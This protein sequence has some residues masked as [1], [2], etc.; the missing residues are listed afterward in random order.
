[1]QGSAA[2]DP[3]LPGLFKE[4]H[5]YRVLPVLYMALQ[6]FSCT[7]QR[8]LIGLRSG[9]DKRQNNLHGLQGPDFVRMQKKSPASLISG[10][11]LEAS[12]TILR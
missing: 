5:C 12:V 8:G 10:A 2:G 11:S 4:V 1:M 6:L 7:S 3:L 9:L